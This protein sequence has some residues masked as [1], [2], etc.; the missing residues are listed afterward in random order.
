MKILPLFVA[1]AMVA[2]LLPAAVAEEAAGNWPRFRGPEGRGVSMDT[3]LPDRWSAT[4][5]VEWKTDL[6]GRGW[7][8]PVVWGNRVFLTTVV[9]P[10]SPEAPAEAAQEAPQKGLYF[11]GEQDAPVE[12]IHLWK[13]TCL[14][15]TTGAILWDKT[16]HEGTP[17]MPVHKKNSYASETPVTDGKHLY[18]TFGNVGIFCF[19]LDGNEVWKHV[20]PPVKMRMG[21]G[22]AASPVLHGGRLFY[23]CDNDEGSY[24]LGLEAATGKELFRVAR[25]GELSNWST[26]FVW[27]HDARTEL[28]TAGWK[29]NRGYDLDGNLLWTLKGMSSI[30]IAAPYVADGLLYI[31]S[32]YVGDRV[33]PVYAIKPGATGDISLAK[34]ETSNAFVAW[35]HPQS[36]P[37]NPST[38]VHDGRLFVL[39]DRGVVSN[40]DAKT[41]A[42]HYEKQKLE[43]SAGF[44]VSPWAVGDKLFCLDEDGTCFVLQ[45]SDAFTPLHSNKLAEDDMCMATPALAGDRLIIRTL[46]RV[47]SIRKPQ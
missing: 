4:E 33:R 11:G 35:S 16:V 5:N 17:A 25:E 22:T 38:L 15:L 14:D 45:S 42:M 30:V 41:G 3:R 27:E 34:G 28:V 32:G 21:W 37:Y 39:Y 47:Y 8:S 46:T 13:V 40:F 18:V 19:D 24:L 9:A 23:V 26:P 36:G 20:L 2:S 43:E 12:G 1:A 7:S 10:P 31:S 29:G 44:T 6:P